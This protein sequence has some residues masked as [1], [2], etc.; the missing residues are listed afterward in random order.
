MNPW[1]FPD[2][3]K[4]A[5]VMVFVDGENLAVRYGKLL[6]DKPPCSHVTYEPNVFVWSE[7]LNMAHHLTC[8]LPKSPGNP[9]SSS[10][11]S[12]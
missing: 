6:G 9:F 11:R 4:N 12:A 5:R 2:T 1:P 10:T 3:I 8:D 7:L